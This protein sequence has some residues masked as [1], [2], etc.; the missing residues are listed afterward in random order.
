MLGRG[1]LAGRH[2]EAHDTRGAR[3]RRRPSCS[4]ATAPPKQ[5]REGSA[6]RRSRP[7]CFPRTSTAS[8]IGSGPKARWAQWQV[9]GSTKRPRWPR[10]TSALPGALERKSPFRALRSP[11]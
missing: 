5:S 9:T 8:S 10:P 4:P 2:S 11:W 7:T 3:H 1:H 6:S